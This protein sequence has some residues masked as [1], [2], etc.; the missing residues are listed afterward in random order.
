MSGENQ[1]TM[2]V[3]QRVKRRAAAAH[4]RARLAYHD[5]DTTSS[6]PCAGDSNVRQPR[7]VHIHVTWE[8]EAKP[9][10]PTGGG[11]RCDAASPLSRCHHHLRL[12][13]SPRRRLETG[14]AFQEYAL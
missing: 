2:T 1:G 14:H 6:V 10:V 4:R 12:P 3:G 5:I 7:Q 11:F 9:A 13:S 8:A